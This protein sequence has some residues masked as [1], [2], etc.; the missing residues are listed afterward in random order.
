MNHSWMGNQDTRIGTGSNTNNSYRWRQAC[1]NSGRDTS[2]CGGCGQTVRRCRDRYT[3]TPQVES[4]TRSTEVEVPTV[5]RAN[6]MVPVT[7]FHPVFKTV[8][9]P[10]ISYVTKHRVEYRNKIGVRPPSIVSKSYSPLAN[11]VSDCNCY[12]P[13]CGCAGG[14]Q[15]GCSFPSCSCAPQSTQ[16]GTNYHTT[17]RN[18][19]YVRRVPVKVP[20]QEEVIKYIDQKIAVNRPMTV[21]RKR[22][23]LVDSSA[24]VNVFNRS[25]VTSRIPGTVK[26]CWNEQVCK[27]GS[28]SRCGQ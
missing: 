13:T 21:L 24:K 7:E 3:T 10:V 5:A 8:K 15:C 4:M 2:G 12:T 27:E 25:P 6:R 23:V 22:N 14:S 19:S 11:M 16:L 20:Y 18:S 26:E 1:C 9:V 17:G 28:G